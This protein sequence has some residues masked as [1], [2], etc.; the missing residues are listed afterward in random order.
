MQ[1]RDISLA[2]K[3]YYKMRDKLKKNDYIDR[4]G[5]LQTVE[6]YISHYKD[7]TV[8]VLDED[9]FT[10]NS[11]NKG[12]EYWIT[13]TK[14][15]HIDKHPNGAHTLGTKDHGRIKKHCNKLRGLCDIK[16]LKRITINDIK[17]VDERLET[18]KFF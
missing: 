12:T 11:K 3:K 10:L 6:H 17:D 14:W 2:S 4:F 16:S 15:K 9:W 1:M 7:G 5:E 13:P 8:D 18:V